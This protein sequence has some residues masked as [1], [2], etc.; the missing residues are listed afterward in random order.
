MLAMTENK[1]QFKSQHYLCHP[2]P[3]SYRPCHTHTE[4]NKCTFACI[5]VFMCAIILLPIQHPR[6]HNYTHTQCSQLKRTNEH[7][8]SSDT[9]PPTNNGQQSTVSSHQLTQ[10]HT[11]T[12]THTGTHAHKLIYN[13]YKNYNDESNKSNKSNKN[14]DG[15]MFH[16][17]FMSTLPKSSRIMACPILTHTYKH[18]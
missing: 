10:T 12:P 9:H 11:Q 8:T 15:I 5:N 2:L 3:S 14:N 13:E 7:F 4:W 17:L 1:V 6:S 18:M 16:K